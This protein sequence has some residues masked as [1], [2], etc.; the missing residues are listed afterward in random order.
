MGDGA[1]SHIAVVTGAAS[2]IGR[3]LTL[4]LIAKGY[5]V[6]CIDYNAEALSLLKGELK[7]APYGMCIQVDISSRDDVAAAMRN[8]EATWG[9]IDVLIN[10]AGIIHTFDRIERLRRD[11]VERVFSVNF[12]GTVNMIVEGLPLL[13]R[14][15]SPLLINIVSIAALV[16]TLGQGFYCASKAAVLQ[17]SETL[18]MELSQ[19]GIAV[20]S[21][22]PG[23]VETNIARNAPRP[24]GDKTLERLSAAAASGQFKLGFTS[25]A[26]A[27]R[28]IIAAI[29]RRPRRL[30]VGVDAKILNIMQKLA[31]RLT[32]NLFAR[33]MKTNP[34]LKDALK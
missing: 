18:A 30:Y 29:E 34:I 19:E 32:R 2:G 20:M 27:A 23:A 17:L 31:P 5:A 11:S 22:L 8:V 26:S 3:E 16:P 12:W 6:V 21:V 33:A 9:R 28:T 24:E 13:R 1:H 15:K 14:S 4:Q 10:N 25:A 7:A